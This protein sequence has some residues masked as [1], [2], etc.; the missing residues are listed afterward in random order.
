MMSLEWVGCN[1]ESGRFSPTMTL[2]DGVRFLRD[3]FFEEFATIERDHRTR[4]SDA[5]VE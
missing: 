3:L 2:T 1:L 5:N 4:T